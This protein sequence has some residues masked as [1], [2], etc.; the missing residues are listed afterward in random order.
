[1]IRFVK[2]D[3]GR[4][5]N[6]KGEIPDKVI[7]FDDEDLLLKYIKNIFPEMGKDEKFPLYIKEDMVIQWTV[8]GYIEKVK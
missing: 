2:R 7:E 6:H 4:W 8:I 1:M 5:R 3:T